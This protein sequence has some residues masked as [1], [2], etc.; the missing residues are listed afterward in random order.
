M[1]ALCGEST[2]DRRVCLA[3]YGTTLASNLIQGQAN[4]RTVH[5]VLADGHDTELRWRK[6]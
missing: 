1:Q 3:Y 4:R 6:Y 5:A 2:D